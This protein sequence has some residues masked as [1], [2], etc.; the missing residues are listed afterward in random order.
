MPLDFEVT[1]GHDACFHRALVLGQPD[2]LGLV[3]GDPAEFA[4]GVEVGVDG[5]IVNVDVCPRLAE[6]DFVI[7]D[8]VFCN[9][10]KVMRPMSAMT[11]PT[12]PLCVLILRAVCYGLM[13]AFINCSF[14]H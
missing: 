5:E 9:C 6:E 13:S 11:A 4:V 10:A 3:F 1:A 7:R 14:D 8:L 2:F 12:L